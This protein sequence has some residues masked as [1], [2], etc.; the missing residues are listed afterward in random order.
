MTLEEADFSGKWDFTDGFGKSVMFKAVREGAKSLLKKSIDRLDK[1]FC[2]IINENGMSSNDTFQKHKL[3]TIQL[4][5]K[6]R[7]VLSILQKHLENCF[8]DYELNYEVTTE[9]LLKTGQ[10]V[11][12]SIIEFCAGV[13]KAVINALLEEGVV[14]DI[15][16]IADLMTTLDNDALEFTVLFE[17]DESGSMV[18]RMVDGFTELF[19]VLDELERDVG[20][21][22]ADGD[23]ESVMIDTVR[24]KLLVRILNLVIFEVFGVEFLAK[25]SIFQNCTIKPAGNDQFEVFGPKFL[26][27]L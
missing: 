19:D 4:V 6:T 13:R 5:E 12:F 7:Q 26:N 10:K 14:D 8:E 16:G 23:I 22:L 3:K 11:L 9:K 2:E 21:S 18:K 27:A 1:Q 24:S 25:K 20:E 15:D 17:R